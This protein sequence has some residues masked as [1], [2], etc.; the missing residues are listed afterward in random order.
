MRVEMYNYAYNLTMVAIVDVVAKQTVAVGVQ[1]QMQR[2][3]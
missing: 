3:P 2:G 1:A